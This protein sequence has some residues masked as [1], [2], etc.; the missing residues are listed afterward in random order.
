MSY[1]YE[2]YLKTDYWKNVSQLVKKR[3]GFRCRLCN[4]QHDL[5]AHHRS[6][7]HRGDEQN[8]LGDLTCLC[9]RCHGI[10]HGKIQIGPVAAPQLVPVLV[11]PSSAQ[12]VPRRKKR[13]QLRPD[14]AANPVTVPD[15]DPI[16][17]T[18]DLV[19]QCRTTL[20]G[21]THETLRALAVP[22]PLL[23]GW[24]QRLEGQ[25]ISRADYLRAL[26]G[27]A[28]FNTGRLEPTAATAPVSGHATGI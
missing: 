17:L 19:E 10:F 15:C 20:R 23:T 2:A 25:Q 8:H 5:I 16:K 13:P 14:A 11:L 6:Y 24:P 28:Q 26:A 22:V 21:F 3:D 12:H 4:S 9:Q 27:R 18:R 7:D 1:S